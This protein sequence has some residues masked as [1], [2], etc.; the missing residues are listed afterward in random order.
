MSIISFFGFSQNIEFLEQPIYLNNP[1]IPRATLLIDLRPGQ[2]EITRPLIVSEGFDPGSITN[3]EEQYG[4]E[5]IFDFR[6]RLVPNAG[7]NLRNLIDPTNNNQAY[8]IIYVNWTN[9]TDAIQ[10]NALVLREVIN[11]VNTQKQL[12]GSTEPNVLLGQSMGGIVGRYTLA[13]MEAEGET[14]D[15]RL[16]V[17]HDSPMQGA[18]TP[19]SLQYF[20]RHAYDQYTSAPVLYG[21]VEIVIPTVLN[22]VELMSLGNLD[23][24][25]PSVSD[26]LTL[27]DTP[28]AM[29]MNYHYVDY[30]SNPT[31]AIHNAWQQEFEN[32]GYPTQSRN[33]AI[34]NGN[35]C[36]VDH[37]FD[38]RAKFI[39]LHD[40][41]NPGFWGDLVHLIATP[42]AGV[43]TSDLEL[44][45]LGLLPGSSKY[46]F[47]F[48]LYANPDVNERNRQVY[49]GKIRYEK[50]LLWL[51]PIS[52]TITERSKTAPYGYLPF[53]TY[54][55]GFY[56]FV[57][58]ISFDFEDYLPTGTVVNQR[59]GFIPVV[60][61]LDIKRNNGNVN[62]TDYLKNYAGGNTSETALTSGF[63][64]FIVDFM[65]NSPKNNAHISFQPR[66]GNWLFNELEEEVDLIDDCSVF[67]SDNGIRIMGNESICNSGSYNLN[68]N[69]V[70]PTWSVVSGQH[71]VNLST[72]GNT[73]RVSKINQNSAGVV[74]LQATVAPSK[75]NSVAKT[76]QRSILILQKPEITFTNNAL[77]QALL[78]GNDNVDYASYIVNDGDI[79]PF[80]LNN[81][82]SVTLSWKNMRLSSSSIPELNNPNG[83]AFIAP[84]GD[85]PYTSC[86][87]GGA[88]G[89]NGNVI[90]PSTINS[91]E[92]SYELINSFFLVE[93]DPLLSRSSSPP[94]H[95]GS[96]GLLEV[97][98]TA[99]NECGC[100]T[101]AN[102]YIALPRTSSSASEFRTSFSMSP[103]PANS[104]VNI[105]MSVP[106][107]VKSVLEFPDFRT[108][109]IRR[110]EFTSDQGNIEFSYRL[111]VYNLFTGVSFYTENFDL[112][113]GNPN[114]LTWGNNN[115]NER[116]ININ[117]SS[118][119]NGLYIVSVWSVRENARITSTL[120]V[121]H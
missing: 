84:V 97:E 18:N 63:D 118:W 82:P 69:I 4:T 33:I 59:Y 34:S 3:P 28:A 48:D 62:P 47:D 115:S 108:G 50:K 10:E 99:Y 74:R 15:V 92:D 14:H 46:F 114:I 67:C 20:S 83:E 38:P 85:L 17:A 117:T 68:T 55:G 70:T 52:H 112:I 32:A 78:N 65:P 71:L 45:F 24:A 60:S 7:N 121:N 98:V 11:W 22:F 72:T 66:N 27:Q 19:L 116:Q 43:V 94:I 107:R 81:N 58:N 51:I 41:H 49:W 42:I 91:L 77:T 103:N 44:T 26:V 53:D 76:F 89:L 8:D 1:L 86:L 120:I 96:S 13:N 88:I 6:D 30:S 64:N 12:S 104:F 31:M 79:L 105:N 80:T 54:S 101:K 16:F 40:T 113:Q 37:G 21:L 9:G 35:E 25:F 119:V 106:E 73:V 61:A 36:A 109:Q 56:D 110:V 75:C 100:D 95:F 111:S 102:S 87:S 23:I 93:P 2:L 90:I 29:Q 57:D 39:N 5:D